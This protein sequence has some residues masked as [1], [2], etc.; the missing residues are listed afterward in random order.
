MSESTR[1]PFQDSQETWITTSLSALEI[2]NQSISCDH[3]T[4][5]QGP[6]VDTCTTATSDRILQYFRSTES[7]VD[8]E[9]SEFFEAHNYSS[10]ESIGG[11]WGPCTISDSLPP[12][13]SNPKIEMIEDDDEDELDIVRPF[14]PP[15]DSSNSDDSIQT[16]SAEHVEGSQ[17]VGKFDVVCG[18]GSGIY[19]LEGNR[20]FLKLVQESQDI[21]KRASKECK[22]RISW[23]IVERIAQLGGRFL[24][25]GSE[26]DQNEARKK[27]AQA[28][29][30][31]GKKSPKQPVVNR[32]TS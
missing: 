30:E 6:N 23:D 27:V 17:V 20:H 4:Q 2:M 11:V 16:P 7:N 12:F 15:C 5:F 31:Y 19:F 21:Y 26:I 3:G 29:R 32:F 28:L 1:S 24:K 14:T 22:T 9:M 8:I 10:M 13:A 18:R 25:D